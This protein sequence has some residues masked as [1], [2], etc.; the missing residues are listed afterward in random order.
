M[1]PESS[2]GHHLSS[3]SI[4]LQG[5]QREESHE[6]DNMFKVQELFYYLGAQSALRVQSLGRTSASISRYIGSWRIGHG[7][8]AF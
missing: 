6:K 1:K 7:L 5:F 4:N 2:G 8:P 3:V